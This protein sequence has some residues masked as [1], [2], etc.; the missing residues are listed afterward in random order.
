VK[1]NLLTRRMNWRPSGTYCLAAGHRNGSDFGIYFLDDAS[2]EDILSFCF[3]YRID[4]EN[5]D[6]EEGSDVVLQTD[7]II[8]EE[9]VLDRA[10]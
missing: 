8:L 6:A 2:F 10:C 1:E 9:E 7:W 4:M 5:L 3:I